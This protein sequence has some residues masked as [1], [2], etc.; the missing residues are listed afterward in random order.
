MGTKGKVSIGWDE[1]EQSQGSGSMSVR[2]T[3]FYR[4]SQGSWVEIQGDWDQV[5]SE[6]NWG[7]NKN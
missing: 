3:D 5:K 7:K 1:S 2:M 6:N 4:E